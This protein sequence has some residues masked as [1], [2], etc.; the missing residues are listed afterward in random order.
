MLPYYVV[1]THESTMSLRRRLGDELRNL[2][3]QGFEKQNFAQELNHKN[4][5]TLN[6]QKI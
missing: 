6:S 4:Y 5:N 1:R 2:K 3:L